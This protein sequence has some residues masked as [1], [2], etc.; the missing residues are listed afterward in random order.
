MI[1]YKVLP[2]EAFYIGFENLTTS[3]VEALISEAATQG[4][5]FLDQG[6]DCI[7]VDGFDSE[8]DADIF[9]EGV[10]ERLTM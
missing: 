3:Q 8:R 2:I 10:E 4:Y 7:I 6:G 1:D 5:E 9:M